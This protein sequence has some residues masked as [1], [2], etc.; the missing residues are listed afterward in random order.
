MFSPL[1]GRSARQEPFALEPGV[2]SAKAI[3]TGMAEYQ[4]AW[5]FTP[6]IVGQLEEFVD[7][8]ADWFARATEGA[9]NHPT[10]MPERQPQGSWRR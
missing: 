5:P 6:L 10:Q 8:W 3:W 2:E 1:M 9:L 7:R 4:V